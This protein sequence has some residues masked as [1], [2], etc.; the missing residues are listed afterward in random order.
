MK[1]IIST[2]LLFVLLILPI[3]GQ[4]GGRAELKQLQGPQNPR[5]A[6]VIHGGAG[7]IR[8][9]SMTPEKEKAY[10]AKLTEVL[11]AGY[12]A[13][14]SGKSSLDAVEIAI[15]MSEDARR[16]TMDGIRSRHPEYTDD[17]VRHAMLRLTL[18]DELY[19]AAWP[20]RP[21]LAP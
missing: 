21:L 15:R 3:A 7:V 10:Q 11:L 5:L 12:K 13:L 17:E 2:F 14:Q 18:G 19:A 1:S 8:R 9:G 4:K 20:S 16:I 6:F